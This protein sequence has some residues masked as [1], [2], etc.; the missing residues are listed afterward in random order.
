VRNQDTVGGRG[1]L[2]FSRQ[3]R[4]GVWRQ[5]RSKANGIWKTHEYNRWKNGQRLNFYLGTDN[6][7]Q[8]K[9]H[10]TMEE[11]SGRGEVEFPDHAD[12][13]PGVKAKKRD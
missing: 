2:Q 4:T 1:G 9:S 13:F 7:F 5:E 11:K 12:V 6:F 3:R 10:Y 8:V